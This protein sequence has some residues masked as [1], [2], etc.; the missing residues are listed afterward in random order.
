MRGPDINEK[1][2]AQGFEPVGST[3]AEFCK[4]IRAQ[5]TRWEKVVKERGIRGE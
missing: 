1:M 4:F 2:V 5:L 3:P